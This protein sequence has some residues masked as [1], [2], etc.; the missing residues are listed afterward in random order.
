MFNAL[1]EK[2][3]RRKLDFVD[4]TWELLKDSQKQK[5]WINVCVYVFFSNH[6]II[7]YV[8]NCLY[9]KNCFRHLGNKQEYTCGYVSQQR[10]FSGRGGH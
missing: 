9:V 6:L 3:S 1:D 4:M 8:S 10:H 5:E 2:E 7:Y